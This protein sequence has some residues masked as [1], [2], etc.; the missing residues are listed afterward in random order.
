MKYKEN[1]NETKEHFKAWWNHSSLGRPLLKIVAERDEPKE[2]LEKVK[3]PESPREKHLGVEYN[4]ARLRNYCRTHDFL[5]DSFPSLDLNIGPGS[6]AVYLGSEPVI[7]DDTIWY[8]K[9]IEESWDEIGQLQFDPDNKWWQFHLDVIERA[10]REA[11]GDFLVNIPDIIENLDILSS[12]RG[13]QALCYDLIDRPAIIKNYIEEIDKLYFKYYDPMYEIVKDDNG[14]SSFTAFKI[15]GPGK[16]AK[17]QCD[18]AAMMSP[19]QF[20]EFVQ[21]SLRKQCKELDF[22]VF[23]L[24]GPDAIFHVDALM[25]IPELNALQWTPGAGNPGGGNS[26][27]YDI[28]D[29]VRESGKSLHISIYDGE[30]RDW[31]KKADKLVKRYGNDGLYLLFPVMTK[32]QAQE[33]LEKAE[34]DWN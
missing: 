5:A 26:C 30:F 13:A 25:D 15:W 9:I 29:K 27:W 21:P 14:G 1:W 17:L 8:E 28:F 23:H 33:L 22:S 32:E 12:L 31:V 24:D 11:D 19:E 16:T 18:F 34:S 7:S 3:T 2:P 4:T 20:R 6:M 10:E